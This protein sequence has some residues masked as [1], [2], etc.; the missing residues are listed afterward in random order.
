MGVRARYFKIGLFTIIAM[1]IGVIAVIVLGAGALLQKKALV[2][3]Y[4]EKSVQGLEVGS[5]FKFR[6]VQIGNVEEITLVGRAYPTKH[7]Y[8][9]IRASVFPDALVGQFSQGV[10]ERRSK[11][12][13]E[14]GLRE[15]IERGFRVRLA[16][17]GVT[18]T[19]FLE[20]DYLDPESYPPLE[21]DWE[22]KY[23]YVPSAPSTIARLGESVENILK[24]LEKVDFEKIAENMSN[25]LN[26][27][28][29]TI[30]E[31]NI[32]GIGKQ[33]EELL[34]EVRETNRHID[35]LIT[36]GKVKSV[37]T[38]ASAATA[39][40]RRIMERSEK[41]VNEA[42]TDLSEISKRMNSVAKRLEAVSNDLSETFVRW[43]RISRHLDDL[44]SNQHPNL[45]KTVENMRMIS[46]N[47]REWSETAKRHPSQIIFG[48]PPPPSEPGRK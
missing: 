6:G 37:I 11:K 29:N 39:A 19:A 25:S 48:K 17:Q 12:K 31:A 35:R 30:E 5:A 42:L 44:I 26:V 47:L 20:A 41:P 18:G 10:G 24:H 15:E 4:M 46:E 3:T 36:N 23:P 16:F 7:R 13:I 45:E 34:A 2:E 32:Q 38:D 40:A 33:A 28:T 22:P 27:V 43:K 1:T 8:V 21:I 14:K 9:I